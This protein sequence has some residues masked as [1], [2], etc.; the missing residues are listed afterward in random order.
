MEANDREPWLGLPYGTVRLVEHDPRWSVEFERVAAQ[1]RPALGSLVVAVE[2]VGSTAVAGLIAKP[3]LDVAVGL[4]AEADTLTV[5]RVLDTHRYEFR[6]DAGEEGG[7]VFV[8]NDR[9]L[10]RVAHLHVVRFGDRQW[11]DYLAVRARLRSDSTARA[12]YAD[13]KWRLARQF[14]DDRRAYTAAK[15]SFVEALLATAAPPDSSAKEAA[16]QNGT[17][18]APG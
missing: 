10:H 11:R 18:S 3:I 13:L 5:T 8:L 15:N 14:A 4:T 6:G 17:A 16:S 1:L 2:H 12:D 9:P 7:L